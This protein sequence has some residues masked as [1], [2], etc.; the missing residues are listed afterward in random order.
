MHMQQDPSALPPSGP[1]GAVQG[2]GDYEAARRHREA[3]SR[4]ARDRDVEREARDAAP[5][6]PNEARDMLD[7]EREGRERSRGEDRRDVMQESA[8]DSPSDDK[9]T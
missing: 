8:I 2:E 9:A 6:S 1:G 3:A 5:R 4:H 7:A